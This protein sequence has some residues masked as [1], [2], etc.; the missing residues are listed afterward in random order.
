[1]VDSFSTRLAQ[2][3]A[4]QGVSATELERR[5]GLSR[6]SGTRYKTGKRGKSPGADIVMRIADALHLSPRWL[7][8]GT[9]PMMAAGGPIADPHPNRTPVLMSPAFT[10]A[11]LRVQHWISDLRLAED[12]STE[13]W[14][15]ALDAACVLYGLGLL[16]SP[17]PRARKS[18][19]N[20]PK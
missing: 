5:A 9:G 3:M 10:A 6:G 1:M 7:T 4:L 12:L 8:D 20:E 13:D 11:P 17:R 16:W 15:R 2:A 19:S 18:V 14:R